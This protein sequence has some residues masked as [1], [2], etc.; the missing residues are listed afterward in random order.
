MFLILFRQAF[1]PLIVSSI[2]AWRKLICIAMCKWILACKTVLGSPLVYK[3]YEFLNGYI[4]GRW[5]RRNWALS[6]VCPTPPGNS[7]QQ[8]PEGPPL[9]KK[10]CF[11]TLLAYK[12]WIGTAYGAKTFSVIQ[13]NMCDW[14]FIACAR[15]RPTAS[16]YKKKYYVGVIWRKNTWFNSCGSTSWVGRIPCQW[17]YGRHRAV[18]ILLSFSIPARLLFSLCSP[19]APF[20]AHLNAW[21]RPVLTMKMLHWVIGGDNWSL[22]IIRGQR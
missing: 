19:L 14:T 13:K 7:Q 2:Q 22:Q 8:N 1:Q 6:V 15:H 16:G 11:Y 12:L 18:D 5:R 20:S 3:I 9:Q 4:K 21:N 10:W 17:K